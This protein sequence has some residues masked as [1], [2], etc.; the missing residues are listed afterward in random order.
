MNIF[1]Y[2]FATLLIMGAI[3]VIT[4][5]NPV[6]AVLWLIFVF[7]QGAGLFL[8]L[9]AEFI[10]MTLIIVYVGAVAVLFIAAVLFTLLVWRFFRSSVW[11]YF[12]QL[13]GFAR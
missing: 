3:G 1:F 5:R 13:F 9:G 6:H 11:R 10:A 4:S 12:L 7:C 8:L 2:L